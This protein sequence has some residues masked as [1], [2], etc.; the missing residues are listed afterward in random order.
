[1]DLGEYTKHPAWPYYVATLA[2]SP[3]AGDID[4]AAERAWQAW[5]WFK[6]GWEAARNG[7]ILVPG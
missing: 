3:M 6:L 4:A 7:S 2:C 1:M 5:L